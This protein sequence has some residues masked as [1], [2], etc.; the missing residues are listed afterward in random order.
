MSSVQLDGCG[1]GSKVPW[2]TLLAIPITSIIFLRFFY[3]LCQNRLCDRFGNTIPQGPVGLPVLGKCI[4]ISVY[5][6][7]QLT[8]MAARMFPLSNS[9]PGAHTWQ[10]GQKIRYFVL[11][12]DRQSAIRGHFQ[13]GYCQGSAGHQWRCFLLTERLVYEEPDCVC[14]S[15]D[16][17]DSVQWYLVS[18]DP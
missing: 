15:W 13:P 12:L 2:I 1:P 3:S 11:L 8:V 14:W 18:S 7:Y 9:L 5:W 6:S 10:M 16:N 17:C 4:V